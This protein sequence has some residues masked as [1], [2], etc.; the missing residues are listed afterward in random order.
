MRLLLWAIAVAVALWFAT[1]GIV[2]MLI[3]ISLLR[4]AP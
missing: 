1:P 4:S 2:G 3:L